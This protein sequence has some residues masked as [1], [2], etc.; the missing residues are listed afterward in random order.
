MYSSFL[1]VFF[2]PK[3]SINFLTLFFHCSN[4]NYTDL[5]IALLIAFFIFVYRIFA[6]SIAYTISSV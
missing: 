3:Q 2:V 6:V 4:Y 1:V 5:L